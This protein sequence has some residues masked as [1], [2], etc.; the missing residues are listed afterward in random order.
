MHQR[1]ERHSQGPSLH[2][3][4]LHGAHPFVDDGRLE[5]TNNAA[6]RAM[7]PLCLGRKITFAGSDSG[8]DAA[9]LHTLIE[10]ARLHGVD[11]MAW[12]A[13][14]IARVADQ[15]INRLDDMLPWNL[16]QQRPQAK[17]A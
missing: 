6:E 11:W 17:S 2:D 5:L 12:L 16:A 7:W 1:Q 10:T 9:I 15:P 3:D 8:G 13:D 14:V 4:A